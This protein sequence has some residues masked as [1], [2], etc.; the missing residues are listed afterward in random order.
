MRTSLLSCN[1]GAAIPENYS[2]LGKKPCVCLGTV[3]FLCFFKFLLNCDVL[4]FLS[5]E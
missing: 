5:M 2:Y 3:Y 1:T 4:N